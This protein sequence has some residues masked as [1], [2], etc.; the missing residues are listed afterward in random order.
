MIRHRRRSVGVVALFLVLSVG[1]A[2]CAGPRYRQSASFQSFF[3][4]PKTV[5][6]MPLRVHI[7]QMTAGNVVELMDEWT[8]EAKRNIRT[9]LK[10]GFERYPDIK[11]VFIEEEGLSKEDK[12]LV[13]VQGGV[14]DILSGGISMH[15]YNGAAM[16]W[17]KRKNFDYTFGPELGRIGELATADAVLFCSGSNYIW[18]AGRVTL[19][20]FG[21]IVGA[22]T[23]LNMSPGIGPEWFCMSLA[24]AETGD[25]LWYDI[26]R[27][28]GDLRNIK[29]DRRLVSNLLA[30][31]PKKW[32]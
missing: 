3:D 13:R 15:T 23:G 28:Q 31:F 11:L 1:M 14:F 27:A 30:T 8:E 26:Y 9:A 32:R 16:F 20:V 29:V 18:T 10:E 4:R 17:H 7:R 22:A 5:A 2:G 12:D 25:M 6:V 24:D 19:A 21:T